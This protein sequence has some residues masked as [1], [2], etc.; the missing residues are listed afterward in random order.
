MTT[1]SD[2]DEGDDDDDGG[3]GEN[4]DDDDDDIEA[5]NDDDGEGDDD[6]DDILA[7]SFDWITGMK[8]LVKSRTECTGTLYRTFDSQSVIWK[9]SNA[10]IKNFK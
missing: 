10:R 9:T 7:G 5:H 8:D 2:D 6:D 1:H 3:E 4:D